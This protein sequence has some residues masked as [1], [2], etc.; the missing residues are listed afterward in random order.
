M[1]NKIKVLVLGSSDNPARGHALDYFRSLPEECYDKRLVVM[2]SSHAQQKDEYKCFYN[3]SNKYDIFKKKIYNLWQK[4]CIAL[5]CGVPMRGIKNYQGHNFYISKFNPISAEQILSKYSGFTPDLIVLMW[6]RTFLTPNTIGRLYDLT[7]ARFAFILVDEAHLTGG[8]H[9]TVGCTNY[10]TGCNNCPALR[11]AKK[12]PK[13]TMTEMLKAYTK[14]PKYA[15]GVVSSCNMARK[16][17]LFINSKVFSD[18]SCPQVPELSKCEARKVLNIND[19]EFAALAITGDIRKGLDYGIEAMNM[20]AK[21][22]DNLVLVV[23]GKL[24]DVDKVRESISNNIRLITPGFL[25]LNEML[26]TMKAT[27]CYLNTTIADT[28]PMMVNYSIAL[29]TPI[30][31]FNVGVAQQLVVHQKT[32]YIAEYKNSCSFAEGIRYIHQLPKSE[33]EAMQKNCL[34]HIAYIKNNQQTWYERIYDEWN[35]DA[36]KEYFRESQS[37]E[38]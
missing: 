22:Y 23:L 20:L 25:P 28:G 24:G 6:T 30:V 29:G 1:K 16:S 27:D 13:V 26:L 35:G 14:I 19:D 31:S 32:G 37:S 10:L 11:W 9:Y 18:V 38:S 7:G 2:D 17:P 33:K 36:F 3:L 4:L 8:C 15:C 12:L 5:L 34:E 21:E